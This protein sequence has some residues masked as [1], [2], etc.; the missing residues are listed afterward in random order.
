MRM[1]QRRDVRFRHR[2]STLLFGLSDLPI[3]GFATPG[4]R[5]CPSNGRSPFLSSFHALASATGLEP[6]RP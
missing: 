2:Y 5:M 4:V 1:G 6:A 3:V